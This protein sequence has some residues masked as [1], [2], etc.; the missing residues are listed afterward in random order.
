LIDVNDNPPLGP[1]ALQIVSDGLQSIINQVAPS[2]YEGSEISTAEWDKIRKT[3][4]KN[5]AKKK[6]SYKSSK[7]D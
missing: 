2:T 6:K 1:I 7:S 4:E 5:V 3:K